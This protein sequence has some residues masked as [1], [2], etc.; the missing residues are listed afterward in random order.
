MPEHLSIPHPTGAAAV[1]LAVAGVAWLVAMIVLLRR[2]LPGAGARGPRAGA[3]RTRRPAPGATRPDPDETR[4]DAT[5]PSPDA[6]SRDKGV[7]RPGRARR[8]RPPA[9]RALPAVPLQGQ[10]GPHREAVELT[11]AERA[12]FEGLVRRLGGDR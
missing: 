8:P 7:R 3:R 11:P 2:G 5:S 10:D 6:T 12:A 1:A 4:P 9:G